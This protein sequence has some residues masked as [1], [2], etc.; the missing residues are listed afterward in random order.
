MKAEILENGHCHASHPIYQHNNELR[1]QGKPVINWVY[2]VARDCTYIDEVRLVVGQA[3][4]IFNIDRNYEPARVT[5]T[6]FLD[7]RKTA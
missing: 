3:V 7:G 4:A 1:C 5:V 2:E 6:N